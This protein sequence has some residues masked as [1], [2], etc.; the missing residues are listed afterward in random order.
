MRTSTYVHPE[1]NM[2]R[3]Y[4]PND[5]YSLQGKL[6]YCHPPPHINAEDFQPQHKKF[7]NRESECLDLSATA[8]KKK[9]KRIENVVDKNFFHQVQY[10]YCLFLEGNLWINTDKI[11]FLQEN[12]RALSKGVQSVMGYKPGSGPVGPG[13]AGSEGVMGKPWKKHGNKNKKEKV[14]RLTKHLDA[15]G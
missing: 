13:T 2:L 6:L 1:Q 8:N 7:L 12:V 15:W 10:V 5:F 3:T 9:I 11:S 14:R 4:S